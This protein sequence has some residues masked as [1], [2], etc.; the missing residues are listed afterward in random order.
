MQPIFVGVDVSKATLAV[1]VHGVDGSITL[2]NTAPAVRGWLRSLPP[3]SRLAVE[4][5]NTYH[6]RLVHEA[7]A[8]GLAVYVLDPQAMHHYARSVGQRAKTDALDAGL[9]ARYLAHEHA[10]LVPWTPVSAGHQAI[11][12]L[13]RRRDLLVGQQ[14]ALRQ[15][16]R[17]LEALR[18]TQRDLDAAFR[19]ALA[20]IDALLQKHLRADPP[21]LAAQRRLQAIPGVGPLVSTA[22]ANLFARV[23]LRSADAAVTYAGLDLRT[24]ES[25]TWRG[26]KRLS[27][28]GSGELR[29]LLYL[30]AMTTARHP[31]LR[32]L[33]DRHLA[34]GLAKPAA[35]VILAHRLLRTAWSMVHHAR[36]FNLARFA[37]G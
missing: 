1:A 30:A 29:R 31:A 26:R 33:I 3:G 24:R 5:T 35:Y 9:I 17:D 19:A 32:P 6:R 27:K 25:G 15:S 18:G 8:A 28:R 36:D 16:L 4:S 23:P 21:C 12:E 14:V 2:D 34:R 10:Q 11:D 20:K 7:H 13:I 22:L 37:G